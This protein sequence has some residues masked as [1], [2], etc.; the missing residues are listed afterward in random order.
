[1]LQAHIA[2]LTQELAKAKAAARDA[3]AAAASRDDTIRQYSANLSRLEAEL[4]ADNGPLAAAQA[5]A[6]GTPVLLNTV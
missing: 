5:Q 3:E 2:R 1:M 6:R 4:N